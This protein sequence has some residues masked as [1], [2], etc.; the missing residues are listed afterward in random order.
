MQSQKIHKQ[1]SISGY[2]YAGS[3]AYNRNNAT[4]GRIFAMLFLLTLISGCNDEAVEMKTEKR[5]GLQDIPETSWQ[6]LAKKRIFFG[7]QSVGDNIL[8]GIETLQQKNPNI[9]LSIIKTREA[10]QTN[11][12]WIAHTHIGKNSD[13]LEKISDFSHIMNNDMGKNTDIA[14]MKFCYIDLESWSDPVALFNAY[15]ASMVQL[16]NTF[17]EVVFVHITAPLTSKQTGIKAFI[18]TLLG[19]D[20]RG[21]KDNLVRAK[22]NSLLLQEY[23]DKAPVFDLSRVEATRP[24]GSL[25][26][27]EFNAKT[28][29]SMAPE[30]TDD[31]GHLNSAGR[32][33]VAENL[34]V[35]LAGIK[36][37]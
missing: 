3:C 4:Y 32:S 17:P 15:K 14:F 19:R 29:L 27:I 25:S 22:Y 11:K 24:D 34:L 10:I 23:A 33:V 9:N 30:Y 7:H 31:G 21:V 18:K 2:N 36:S 28:A 6:D 20:L 8:A 5:S 16:E 37:K 12:G 13:P 26:Q 1:Y 35:F